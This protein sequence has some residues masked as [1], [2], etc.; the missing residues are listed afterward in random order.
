M[1]FNNACITVG[2]SHG[3]EPAMSGQ[4]AVRQRRILGL[5]RCRSGPQSFV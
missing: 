2:I 3:W 5:V 4:Q 1:V